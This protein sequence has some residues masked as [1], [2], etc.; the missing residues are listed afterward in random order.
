MGS[1]A[2]YTLVGAFVLLFGAGLLGFA[3]WLT[4]HGGEEKYDTYQVFMDESVSGLTTNA[5]VKYRGVEVG[6]VTK[7]ELDPNNPER[8]RL[9][10][11]VRHGTPIKEDTHATL[12]FHGI[13]GLA[14]IE[15][16]GSKGNARLLKPSVNGEPPTIPSSPSTFTRLDVGLSALVDKSTD[17][18]DR[19]NRLLSDENLANFSGLLKDTRAMMHGVRRVAEGL[20]RQMDNLRQMVN[21][22]I[23]MEEKV[24]Q[25]FDDVQDA[26]KEVEQLSREIRGTY[27]PLGEEAR[28]I[29][30][31]GS[32]IAQ[33]LSDDFGLVL[34]EL[35]MTLEKLQSNPGDLLFSR[36]KPR[37]GPGE[38]AFK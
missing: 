33:S 25:A 17:A 4:Q 30:S 26:S 3:Y 7:I 11:Q 27:I 10:L 15:L 21:N 9:L 1:N 22:A 28:Q 18:L 5:S 37:P 35:R 23:S 6:H 12:S 8:V 16:M 38:E 13:T 34:E 29:L 32:E 24:S 20:D 36:S 31:H 14:Y 19:V 2:N